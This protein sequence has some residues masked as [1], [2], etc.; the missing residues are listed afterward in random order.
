MKK[1]TRKRKDRG[2]QQ[3]DAASQLQYSMGCCTYYT[4]GPAYKSTFSNSNHQA[5]VPTLKIIPKMSNSERKLPIKTCLLF[6]T[7]Y[8]VTLRVGV[9]ERD[10]F[11]P[12]I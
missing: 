6:Y 7:L 11:A 10:F 9:N 8:I 3:Y 12:Y 5:L 4:V 1:G 2:L